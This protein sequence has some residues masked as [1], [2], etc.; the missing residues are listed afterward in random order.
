MTFVVDCKQKW[1]S[2]V[3]KLS[4]ARGGG[5]WGEVGWGGVMTFAVDCKQT[6]KSSVCKLSVAQGGGVGGGNDSVSCYVSPS[7][8]DEK[9]AFFSRTFF[10]KAKRCTCHDQPRL[11]T[12]C[13]MLY[14]ISLTKSVPILQF[15]KGFSDEVRCWLPR[16]M[17][18]R[19]VWQCSLLMV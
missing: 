14:L 3:Y 10:F 5:G 7:F 6:W 13:A 17:M 9:P 18:L 2:S 1:K 15:K 11:P 12:F 8:F 4:V 16:K 19:R